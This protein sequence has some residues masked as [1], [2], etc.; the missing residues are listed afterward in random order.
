[1]GGKVR[2]LRVFAHPQIFGL[3]REAMLRTIALETYLGRRA[4]RAERRAPQDTPV[5][6]QALIELVKTAEHQQREEVKTKA[7]NKNVYRKGDHVESADCFA[8]GKAQAPI[9]RQYNFY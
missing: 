4:A 6:A 1:V 8:P 2:E 5:S 9:T 7:G 3:Y